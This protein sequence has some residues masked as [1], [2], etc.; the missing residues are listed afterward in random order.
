MGAYCPV[1]ISSFHQ[2]KLEEYLEKLK[3]ALLAEKA[4]FCGIIY[5]GL[6]LTKDAVKVLEYN[7]RFGDPETQPLMMYLKCD[8]LEIFLNAADGN[9]ENTDIEWNEG[10]SMCVVLAAQ[11]YPENPKKG[12]QIRGIEE[13]E[14]EYGVKVFY[15]GVKLLPSPESLS[16]PNGSLNDS[17]LSQG[18]RALVS[19]G[20]RVLC[21]CKTGK[22]IRKNIYKAC[23]KID[24]CDKIFRTDI[25]ENA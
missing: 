24:F 10:T 16:S 13:A 1:K 20:G 3:N 11:G 21:V 23:E 18:E 15:A 19:N 12:C 25:G 8:L 22:D 5:S 14:K 4:D 2:T 7:M 9:L 17:T 6:M